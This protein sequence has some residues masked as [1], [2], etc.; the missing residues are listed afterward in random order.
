[1]TVIGEWSLPVVISIHEPFIIFSLPCPAEE[2]SDRVALVG[3]WHPAR[4]NPPHPQNQNTV[5]AKLLPVL[6]GFPKF[7]PAEGTNNWLR[8]LWRN[9]NVRIYFPVGQSTIALYNKS[10][11]E[12][13]SFNLCSSPFQRPFRENILE[14][15]FCLT[16]KSYRLDNITFLPTSK[17]S[18]MHLFLLK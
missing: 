3:T 1:M 6:H 15:E 17:T 2:G 14:P 4:V 8:K 18:L 16:W 5:I 10:K 11:H 9:S 13:I 12:M 7:P